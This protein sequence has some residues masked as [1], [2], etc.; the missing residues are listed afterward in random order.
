MDILSYYYFTEL[1]K[2]MNM[3]R[4]AERLYVSQQTISNHIQR[5]EEHYG[6]QLFYRKPSLS[7]TYAGEYALRFAQRLL[8]EEQ[9][10]EDFLCDVEKR[11]IGLLRFG[12]SPL[13][14]YDF[15]PSVIPAFAER[16][17]KI[18]LHITSAFSSQLEPMV[19]EGKLDLAIT[20][21]GDSK[22]PSLSRE[23]LASD[24]VFLCIPDRLLSGKKDRA[25]KEKLLQ[26]AEITDCGDIPLA[27]T[28]NRMG[29]VIL[30][31]FRD[32]GV[33]PKTYFTSSDSNL[34]FNVC[35]AGLAGAFVGHNRLVRAGA[36]LPPDLNIFPL[37]LD[38][39]FAVQELSL[40]CR[41]DR[42]LPAYTRY[43]MELLRKRVQEMDLV[44]M[45]RIV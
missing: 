23:P 24:Q 2:D 40:V 44:R 20:L 26:G 8:V 35:C 21:D 13:R 9:N 31:A 3:S 33:V 38:G 43:L 22:D 6:T 36:S 39:R 15:L 1:C 29:G 4:T 32:A 12:A 11:E 25:W 7:L 42:Y 27:L 45:E 18:E 19:L 14:L 41:K 16:Y 37:I 30:Q 17:P 5:M 34:A 10:L 28:E